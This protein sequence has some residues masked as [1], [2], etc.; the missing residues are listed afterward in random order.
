MSLTASIPIQRADGPTAPSAV[1]APPFPWVGLIV[2]GAAVFL[3]IT[4]EMMPVGL[5]PEMSASLDVDRSQIGLLVSWFAFTVVV[6]STSLAHLTRRVSRHGLVVAVLLVFALSN[7]LTAIAPT[8]EFVVASRVLGGMAH[9]IFWSVVGAYAGHLVPKEQ[10]G[11]AVS[12]TVAGGTLAF[13]FGVPVAT[14]AGHLLGWRLTFILLAVLMVAGAALVWRFVPT[15][16]HH[17]GQ[18]ARGKTAAATSVPAATPPRRDPT[19]AAVALICAITAITMVGHYTFYTY[20]TPFLTDGLGVGSS[21]VPMMLFLFGIAGA[22]GLLLVGTVFGP[23]PQLG[24]VVGVAV[25]ALSVTVLALTLLPVSVVSMPVAVVAF[26]LWGL[27]FGTL[28]PLLQTRL[29]HSA[30]ARIRD[31]ASA[32]YT[33]AFN[34]GIGAGAL[35]GALLLDTVGLNV[36]PWVYVGLLS[37]ALALVVVTDRMS[38]RRVA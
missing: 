6:T 35:L 16:T 23:R 15:V 17:A 1:P 21:D 18:Q 7:V 2:L 19:T 11:R 37:L 14:L 5:L 27:A 12:I 31:T 30:S 33:T 9:G 4:S 10:I 38:S 29:L 28:P 3:S 8:Y 13:I 32:F 26:M 25:S 24:L 20:V 36:V 22:V 34:A